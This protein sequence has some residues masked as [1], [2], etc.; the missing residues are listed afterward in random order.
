M[1]DVDHFYCPVRGPGSRKLV[2]VVLGNAPSEVVTDLALEMVV[3]HLKDPNYRVLLPRILRGMEEVLSREGS[4]VE[5]VQE[6][7]C[8]IARESE[9]ASI[10]VKAAEC[11]FTLPLRSRKSG[12]IRALLLAQFAGDL[13]EARALTYARP[14]LLRRSGRTHREHLDWLQELRSTIGRELQATVESVYRSSGRIRRSRRLV[15]RQRMT[16]EELHEPIARQTL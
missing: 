6:A 15:K 5:D 7:L 11:L 8:H 14:E 13:I 12:D 3:R 4:T 2:E 16:L 9:V 10:A 1:P